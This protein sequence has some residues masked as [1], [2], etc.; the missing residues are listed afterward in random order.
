MTSKLLKAAFASTVAVALAGSAQAVTIANGGFENGLFEVGPDGFQELDAGSTAM[1]GWTIGGNGV[2]WVSS[3][4]E[5]L[6]GS[7]KSIDLHQMNIGSIEQ[8]ITGLT[9]GL[10]YFISFFVAPNNSQGTN[11]PKSAEL[12]FGSDS[13][14]V[15]YNTT[16][17]NTL[18]NMGWEERTYSFVASQSDQLLKLTGMI[19]PGDDSRTGLAVDNFSISAAPDSATWLTMI[20]GFGAAGTMLRR[21]RTKLATA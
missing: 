12:A 19:T 13:V 14:I 18:A 5:Q 3:Y 15:T 21:Q 6:P 7:S 10:Q 20:V 4:W 17:A 16:G 1:T 2:D 9:P 8:L 11:L